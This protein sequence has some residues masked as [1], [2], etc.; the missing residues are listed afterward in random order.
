MANNPPDGYSD[1][2]LEQILAIPSYNGLSNPDGTSSETASQ[3]SGGAQ[4][5]F[6]PLGLSLD[7][8]QRVLF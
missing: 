7:N 4:Q 2:F 1:D 3:L 5:P 6:F 8:G